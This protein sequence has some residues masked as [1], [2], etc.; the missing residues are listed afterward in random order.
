M[1]FKKN[2]NIRKYLLNLFEGLRSLTYMTVVILWSISR[3]KITF[4]KKYKLKF[5]K[6]LERF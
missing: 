1:L 2:V 4:G 5:L 3:R 6:L